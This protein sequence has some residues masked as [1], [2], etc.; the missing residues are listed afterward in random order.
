MV[1]SK[2]WELGDAMGCHHLLDHLAGRMKTI[3]SHARKRMEEADAEDDDDVVSAVGHYEPMCSVSLVNVYT[4]ICAFDNRVS[5]AY[6]VVFA[7][8]LVLPL[9]LFK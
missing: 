6:V 9:F 1:P 7:V 8:G 4:I 5:C 3:T 2:V